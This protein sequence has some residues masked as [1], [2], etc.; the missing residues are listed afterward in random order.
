M[1]KSTGNIVPMDCVKSLPEDEQKKYQETRMDLTDRQKYENKIRKYD[2]CP[3]GS[4]RK[5][6]FCCFEK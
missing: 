1:D 2:L 4:G 3:C 5:F 6:K